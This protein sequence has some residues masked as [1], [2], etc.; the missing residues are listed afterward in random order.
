VLGIRGGLRTFERSQ[1]ERWSTEHGS[2]SESE[3]DD[4]WSDGDEDGSEDSL[5]TAECHKS[6]GG[7]SYDGNG[8]V[9]SGVDGG[10]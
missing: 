6:M 2:D 4:D 5:Q 8:L 3:V 9:S 7:S 10:R 1:T